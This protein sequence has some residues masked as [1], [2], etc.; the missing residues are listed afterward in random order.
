MTA[1]DVAANEANKTAFKQSDV[2]KW[3]N[4]YTGAGEGEWIKL[5]SPTGKEATIPYE[6]YQ[7]QLAPPAGAKAG[8]GG[9]NQGGYVAGQRYGGRVYHGG[10]PFDENNWD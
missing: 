4:A 6:S 5:R 2:G 7:K 9:Q 1:A 10:D 3:S 8:G